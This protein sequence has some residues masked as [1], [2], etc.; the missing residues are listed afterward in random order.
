MIW[1]DNG[2]NIGK[3]LFHDIESLLGI[4]RL[5]IVF[6]KNRSLRATDKVLQNPRRLCHVLD[7][8]RHYSNETCG[9]PF[10]LRCRTI[11]RRRDVETD[12]RWIVRHH[13]DNGDKSKT[14]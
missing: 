6:S 5:F 3:W 4:R 1:S 7:F 2:Q 11:N 8:P 9:L 10:S 13:N 12:R 14:P